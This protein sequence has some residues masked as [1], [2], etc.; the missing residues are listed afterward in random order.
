MRT[1]AAIGLLASAVVF[2]GGCNSSPQPEAKGGDTN[3]AARFE[4]AKAMTVVT[5]RD[6]ALAKVA[7]DAAA[8]G[9]A[10]TVKKC[11]REI[12]V[13]TVKDDTAY[14]AAL[15]LAK[16]GKTDAATEV[17]KSINVVT[18]RDAA[19]GKLAKGDYGK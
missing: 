10:E 2:G 12:N 7:E 3:F 1:V 13:L 19:L 5:D 6:A 17:A 16:V 9:D 8:G 11:I 18:R 4:A 15:S 14:K